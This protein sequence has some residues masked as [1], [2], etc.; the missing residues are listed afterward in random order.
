MMTMAYKGVGGR[1][2]KD[3]LGDKDTTGHFVYFCCYFLGLFLVFVY[4]NK[5]DDIAK[6]NIIYMY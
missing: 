1:S 4:K 6:E 3:V 2:Y 5:Y